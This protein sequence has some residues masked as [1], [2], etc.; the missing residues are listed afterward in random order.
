MLRVWG[1]D[2]P[3]YLQ[4]HITDDCNLKCIHCYREGGKSVKPSR[5]DLMN[6]LNNFNRF[7][8]STGRR[9]RF[10]ISGG[11]PFLS[12]DLFTILAEAKN[13]GYPVRVLSNATV[14]THNI[15]KRLG[16]SGCR[17]VQASFEGS[18]EIH[19]KIRGCGSFKKALEGIKILSEHD[20]EVTVMMTVSDINYQVLKETIELTAPYARRF[21][22]SRLV[23]Q[24]AGKDLSDSMLT[25]RQVR[26]LFKEFYQL[27]LH[28]EN[29]S[30]M[31]ASKTYRDPL[32]QVFFRSV[33]PR[34]LGGCSIGF[35]GIC[36]DT[37][38]TV[39]PCRRL[40]VSLGNMHDTDLTEIWNSG[41]LQELRNR[42]LL[43]GKCGKCNLRWQCGGCRAIAYAKTGDYLSEDPQCFN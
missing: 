8:K 35:N 2:G 30:G 18:E 6:V 43:K 24:G 21:A 29:R 31:Q 5:A 25:A 37:D 42:D 28:S 7:L 12:E 15:A 27:K 20:I 23:P 33:N 40:P 39:Y 11:E 19:D 36:V 9:G 32:W 22:F 14:M 4:W 1:F 34:L 41:I 38:G 16:V 3:F 17:I 26:A 10:Q 13:H